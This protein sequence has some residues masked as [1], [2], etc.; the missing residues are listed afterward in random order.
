M[1]AFADLYAALDATTKTT[2]KVEVLAGYFAAAAP[3]DA[4]WAVYFLSGRKPRQAV[5]S[6]RLRLW[7]R[8]LAGVPEWL[9]DEAYHHVGDVA[10]TVALLLPPAGHAS[11]V[12]LS[13]WVEG[14]LLPLRDLE[15]EA[16]R[17]AVLAAWAELDAGQRFVWNK[18]ITGEFRVGVSQL[19]VVRALA[20]VSKLPADVIS[21]RLMGA[22]EPTPAFYAGLVAA[23]SGDAELSRPYPFFLA[24]PLE[25]DPASL[26][27]VAEWQAEWKWDGIRAQ[28]VRRGG[29]AFVWSRGEELVTDR[30]PEL[31]A[32]AAALPDGTVLDGELLPWRGGQV[33]PFAD[34]QKRIGR[35]TVGKKLL[36][37]VPVVLVAYDLVEVDGT[38]FRERPLGERRAR[39]EALVAA[40]NH[41]ALVLSPRIEPESWDALARERLGSRERRVE[42][43]ML[44]RRD[45]PYRV[46]RVRG[47][48][49]KWKVEPFAVD[50]VLIN[51]QGGHGKRS[52]LFTDYTFAVWDGGALVPIAKAYSG[53]TDAEIKKVD[54][55]V[56]ANTLEKFGPVRAVKPELVF[57]LG[58]EGIQASSRHKSG[59]AV[60]FPRMLRWRTDKKPEEADTLDRVKALLNAPAEG[61]A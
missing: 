57:E 16:Q 1:K 24:H 9:F 21:H 13:R 37:E 5:P 3:D 31:K 20:Q 6:K 25:G 49:W 10:E 39:L 8:E 47:D 54:A 52:G 11:D 45:S 7:A 55:F 53:L 27:P 50:A 48:W 29:Q 32:M 17:A 59:V 14:H 44:K 15:E 46:G 12:P 38:D 22:W 19:L 2:G 43:V 33:Q 58:F 34:L 23:D 56:R 18:L 40:T 61:G 36:D 28:V 30:Y 26:G 4:A 51:A 41:P 42:G 35:K 60:R